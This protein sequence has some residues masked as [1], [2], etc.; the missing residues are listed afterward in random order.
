MSKIRIVIF[1]VTLIISTALL[2]YLFP[3]STKAD[4]GIQKGLVYFYISVLVVIS[5]IMS[6]V[7]RKKTNDKE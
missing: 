6:R 4:T 5:L 3:L 1:V 2:L 7:L